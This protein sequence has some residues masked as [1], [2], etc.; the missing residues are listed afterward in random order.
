MGS[1]MW[2]YKSPN[3]GYNY[4]YPLITLLLILTM[5]LQVDEIVARIILNPSSNVLGFA[6]KTSSGVSGTWPS[7]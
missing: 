3:T 6:V 5:K 2:S 1:Y 7:A 4:S